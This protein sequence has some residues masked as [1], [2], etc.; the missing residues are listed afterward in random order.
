VCYVETFDEERFVADTGGF[1]HDEGALVA[2]Y[3][4]K[5]KASG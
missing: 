4:S 5:C 2:A 1:K 3:A